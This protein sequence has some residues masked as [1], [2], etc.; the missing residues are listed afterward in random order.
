[1]M[2]SF[3]V[4]GNMIKDYIIIAWLLL[5]QTAKQNCVNLALT[6]ASNLSLL[7]KVGVIVV[8]IMQ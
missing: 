8:M 5:H 1:M 6:L 3:C 4:F 7:S 2:P